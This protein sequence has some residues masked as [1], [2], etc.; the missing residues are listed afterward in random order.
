MKPDLTLARVR[1]AR[2]RISEKCDHDPK[3]LVEYY[4]KLQEQQRDRVFV[5]RKPEP[6]NGAT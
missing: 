4:L 5:L 3:R 2:R 1:E 6:P